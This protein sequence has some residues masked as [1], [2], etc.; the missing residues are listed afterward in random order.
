ML[1]DQVMGDRLAATSSHMRSRHGPDKAAGILDRLAAG[2]G[3]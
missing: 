2:N 3:R 1:T